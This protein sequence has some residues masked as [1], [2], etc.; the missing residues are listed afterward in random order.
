M[1]KPM[2]GKKLRAQAIARTIAHIERVENSRTGLIRVLNQKTTY[3]Y[4]KDMYIEDEKVLL[5]K[6]R[7]LA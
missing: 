3:G 5:E 2:A 6:L 1:K 7:M 4:T